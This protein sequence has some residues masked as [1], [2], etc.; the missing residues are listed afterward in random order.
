MPP[1]QRE[2]LPLIFMDETLV[3]IPNVGVDAGLQA[4][5]DE[6]GLQVEWVFS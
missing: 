6:M 3:I 5:S 2:Q 4:G 1:W